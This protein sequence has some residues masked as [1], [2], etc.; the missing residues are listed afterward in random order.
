MSVSTPNSECLQIRNGW[1][2]GVLQVE[3]VVGKHRLFCVPLIALLPLTLS[4]QIATLV[5][6]VFGIG[7]AFGVLGGGFLGQWLYNKR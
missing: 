3:M 6:T 1:D 4:L 2:A 7:A 5:I